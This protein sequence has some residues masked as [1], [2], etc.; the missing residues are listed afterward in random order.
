MTKNNVIGNGFSLPELK[1]E[2]NA[3]YNRIKVLDNLVK[4]IE[5]YEQYNNS[6]VDAN[7]ESTLENSSDLSHLSAYEGC[8][9]I[10]KDR[11]NYEN[12]TSFTIIMFRG[13]CFYRERAKS[14][15]VGR[16]NAGK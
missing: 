16:Y 2:R 15:S 8:I 13:V 1:A 6:S 11:G 4:A 3:L 10:L 12:H 9:R 7:H 5:E 14:K